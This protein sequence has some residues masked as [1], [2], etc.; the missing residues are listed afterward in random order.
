MFSWSPV[1]CAFSIVKFFQTILGTI[2]GK[3]AISL[4]FVSVGLMVVIVVCNYI[5]RVRKCV[6][7]DLYVVRRLLIISTHTICN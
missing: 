2:G 7:Y 1:V 6:K 3:G 4:F 5:F